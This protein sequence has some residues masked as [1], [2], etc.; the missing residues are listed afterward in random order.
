MADNYDSCDSVVGAREKMSRSA[1]LAHLGGRCKSVSSALRM[2]P[3]ASSTTTYRL[4]SE[5][6]GDDIIK[7]A[8]VA[9]EESR[10]AEIAAQA[11][12]A[13]EGGG[14]GDGGSGGEGDGGSGGEGDGG[15]GGDASPEIVK[16]TFDALMA[17]ASSGRELN[18]VERCKMIQVF[19]LVEKTE[20]R[21]MSLKW[22]TTMWATKQA[23]STKATRGMKFIREECEALFGDGCVWSAVSIKSYVKQNETGKE[24]RKMGK[25]FAFPKDAEENLSHF[26]SLLRK[27]KCPVY[28]ETV[29][30]YAQGLISGHVAAANFR[31]VDKHGSVIKNAE[32]KSTWDMKKFNNWY[33]RRFLGDNPDLTTGNQRLQ[34]AQRAKW[35]TAKNMRT[36]YDNYERALLEIGAAVPNPMYDEEDKDEDGVPKQPK[37][38]FFPGKKDRVFSFDETRVDGKTHGDGG[39]RHGKG[40]R[41]VR[42]GPDDDGETIGHKSS[43]QTFSAVG[44]SNAAFQATPCYAVTATETVSVEWFERG[45]KTMIGGKVYG[46]TGNCNTKGSVTGELAI[47]YVETCI[48][49]TLQPPVSKDNGAVI[50]C[51]GVGCHMT[52]AFLEY[53][54]ENGFILVLRTPFCSEKQQN[55]D[56]VSFWMLKN[57]KINGFYKLKQQAV[58]ASLQ[59]PSGG[60][61]LKYPVLFELFA[62]AWEAA[63]SE[64]NNATGWR[65]SGLMPFTARPYWMQLRK[66]EELA[67][68]RNVATLRQSLKRPLSTDGNWEA[69]GGLSKT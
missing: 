20:R 24:P 61:Q 68:V 10:K 1:A 5:W 66:E 16:A 49:P 32:G 29:I 60:A 50:V 39:G 44:G 40:E 57:E 12:L 21:S 7:A 17:A 30:D 9:A 42:V 28:K 37:M 48:K 19:K 6:S 46:T 31:R 35:G 58:I 53:C 22:A 59:Q 25:D 8:A 34:D 2:F 14:E 47:E 52:I 4:V 63:F 67:R 41:I 13:S 36:H 27:C 54:S 38:T 3:E 33:Y 43:A 26:V 62:K 15:S 55:E 64:E 65:L 45:P 11:M 23:N 56:L 69:L 18:P 51:D